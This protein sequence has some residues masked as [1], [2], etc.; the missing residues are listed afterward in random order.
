MYLEVNKLFLTKST[1]THTWK[2]KSKY[3]S[4]STI[5]VSEKVVAIGLLVQ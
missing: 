5:E 2:P 3:I 4:H 1:S